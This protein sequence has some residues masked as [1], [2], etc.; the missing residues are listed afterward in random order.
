MLIFKE[1]TRDT[2]DSLL[3]GFFEDMPDSDSSYVMEIAESLLSEE[4]SCEYALAHSFGS[5]IIRVFDGRYSFIYPVAVCEN[6]NPLLA[7]AEVREYTV[8][9]EIPLIYTDV[10]KDDLGGLLQMFRHANIDAADP[11]ASSYTVTILT[12]AAVLSEIPEIE[13]GGDIIL[14]EILPSDDADYARL[15][16]DEE[17]NRYWGYDYKADEPNPEDSYFRENVDREFARGV[18]MSFAIRRDRKF[19]GEAILYS[20]NCLGGCDCAIRILPEFRRLGIAGRV[21]DGLIEY[22]ADI[23]IVEMQARVNVENKAS[24]R[25]CSGRFEA[26][27]VIDENTVRFITRLVN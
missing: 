10:P 5:I 3:T 21:L 7:A 16:K 8:K 15:C 23:G 22:A 13:L 18:A 14:N 9:E 24:Y 27:S 17:T 25:L 1:L 6:A 12:E 26:E 2:V 20:F 19:V 11:D 4:D